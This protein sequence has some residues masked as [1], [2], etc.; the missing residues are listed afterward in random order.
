MK[1]ISDLIISWRE[2][3]GLPVSRK[4]Y[5]AEIERAAKLKFMYSGMVKNVMETIAKSDQHKIGKKKALGIIEKH[6]MTS[7]QYLTKENNAK[8]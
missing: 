1:M 8:V 6:C 5:H 7:I 3:L 4:K 2:A